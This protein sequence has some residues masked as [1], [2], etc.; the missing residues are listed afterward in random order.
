ML[1]P[2]INGLLM[3]PRSQDPPPLRLQGTLREIPSVHIVENKYDA[4]IIVRP[5]PE[6][7]APQQL[8]TLREMGGQYSRTDDLCSLNT[9]VV[10]FIA[11]GCPEENLPHNSFQTRDVGKESLGNFLMSKR[12]APSERPDIGT[13][14]LLAA[15]LFCQI[16]YPGAIYWSRD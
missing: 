11:P 13:M 16:T 6:D 7:V 4:E 15:S 8:V 12:P 5:V 1:I 3:Q 14:V 10:V 2:S 9:R